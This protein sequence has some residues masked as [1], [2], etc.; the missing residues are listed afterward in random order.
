MP[1]KSKKRCSPDP[2]VPGRG[3]ALPRTPELLE[4]A[5]DAALACAR[6]THG[7]TGSAAFTHLIL[8]RGGGP[9]DARAA[10]GLE[11]QAAELGRAV[12]QAYALFGGGELR[13]LPK[14]WKAR[15]MELQRGGPRALGDFLLWMDRHNTAGRRYLMMDRHYPNAHAAAFGAAYEV[16]CA[17]HG[18]YMVAGPAGVSRAV[19]ELWDKCG[20]AAWTKLDVLEAGIRGEHVEALKHAEREREPELTDFQRNALQA[21]L[22]MKALGTGQRRSLPEVVRRAGG[23]EPDNYKHSMSKLTK[24]GLVHAQSGPSG[25]YRLTPKGEAL[26]RRISQ[27]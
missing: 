23:R 15:F 2:V 6:R 11:G 18:G 8:E 16:L 1:K 22:E 24:M 27:D 5:R 13:Q 17:W 12:A 21:L 9:V 3:E 14:D 10:E 4:K 26:A 19:A 20:R 25:G 7:L